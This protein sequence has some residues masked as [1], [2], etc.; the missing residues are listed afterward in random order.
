MQDF[1]GLARALQSGD[2]S[3]AQSAFK[4]LQSDL[5]GTQGKSQTSSLLDPNTAVGQ[6]FKAVQ[7]AL[8]SG[9]IKAAQA[10][11]GTLKQGLRGAWHAHGHHHHH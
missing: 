11:F 2:I 7:D 4:T 9:D 5:Q 8:Q 10:A 1:K 3:A 6:E